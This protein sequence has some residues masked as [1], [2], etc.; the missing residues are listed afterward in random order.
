MIPRSDKTEYLYVFSGGGAGW[1]WQWDVYKQCLAYGLKPAMVGGTSAGALTAMFAH[2]NLISIGDQYMAS[3]YD[4]SAG[5][6]FGPE[7]ARLENGK[8]IIDRN[9]VKK[10]LLKGINAFDL[11]KLVTKKG[12]DKLLGQLRD[13]IM[14]VRSFMN[15]KPLLSAIKTTL[16]APF[17]SEIPFLFNTL[18]MITGQGVE[19]AADQFDNVDELAYAILAST[20]IPVFLPLVPGYKTKDGSYKQLADG[21]LRAGSPV[22]QMF[23][24][25]DP[26]KNQAIIVLNINRR[27]IATV[28]E[29]NS[30]VQVAGRSVQIMLNEILLGDLAVT[31]ERNKAA[32]RYGESEGYKYVPIYL[33]EASHSRGVF[34]FSPESAL[35][36]KRVAPTD[37][38]NMFEIKDLKALR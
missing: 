17:E 12:Q 14:E 15:N 32:Q 26:R 33:C 6:V 21:G 23:E 36:Q 18:D 10:Q 8:M 35:E 7:L 30:L 4:G 3:A 11:I 31:L 28:S 9:A 34:D 19:N 29:V 2:R 38:D 24:R 22:S 37:F 16:A 20:N 5:N 1:I 27:E 13:N 25:I